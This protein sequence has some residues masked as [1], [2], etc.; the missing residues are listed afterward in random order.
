MESE[1]IEYML[2]ECSSYRLSPFQS[3][4]P[5]GEMT[6]SLITGIDVRHVNDPDVIHFP[7]QTVCLQV[8]VWVLRYEGCDEVIQ[9]SDVPVE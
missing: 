4:V 5:E 3:P 7:Y 9:T 2:D 8:S 1:L 6:C